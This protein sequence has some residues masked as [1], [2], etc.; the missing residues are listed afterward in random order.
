MLK[1]IEVLGRKCKFPVPGNVIFPAYFLRQ[2]VFPGIP[3]IRK[4]T[5]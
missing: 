2:M 1:I 4:D 5:V 3:M